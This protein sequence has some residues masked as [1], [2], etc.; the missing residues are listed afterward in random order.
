MMPSR[1]ALLALPAILCAWTPGVPLRWRNPPPLRAPSGDT[2]WAFDTVQ[3]ESVYKKVEPIR[4]GG[5]SDLILD[6]SDPTGSTFWS[7]SDRGPVVG[8]ASRGKVY[9][10]GNYHQKIY[11][12]RAE[13]D[14]L[15]VLEID[16]IRDAKGRLATGRSSPFHSTEETL[17]PLPFPDSAVA[18]PPGTVSLGM[19]SAGFDF[20][21]IASDGAGGFYLSDEMGP[22]IAHVPAPAARGTANWDGT[23]TIDTVWRP[24]RELPAALWRRDPNSGLEG[25]CR[26]PGGKVIGV[27]QSPLPN[28]VAK[29]RRSDMVDS[30]RVQRI[31]VRDAAGAVSE[32]VYLNDVKG[33]KRQISNIKVGACAALDENRILVLEHGKAKNRAYQIDLW[34]ADLSG[35]TDVHLASDP[36]SLGLLVSGRTLEE[37]GVDSSALVAAVTPVRKSLL[38]ADV[39]TYSA[40]PT[41]KPEGLAVVDD[42]TVALSSDN[43][44]GVQPLNDDGIP[45]ALNSDERRP[46][47]MYLRT[48]SLGLPNSGVLGR[49]PA[50]SRLSV[51]AAAGGWEIRASGATEVRVLDLSGKRLGS[52]PVVEGRAVLPDRESSSRVVVLDAGSAGRAILPMAR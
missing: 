31:V 2:L 34:I 35:A 6:A 18:P 51:S 32:H 16:S 26:T 14:S 20:E 28:A 42:S 52:L 19:D 11:R 41:T 30:S 37:V 43:D 49:R 15:R 29:K 27:M 22:W 40:W 48:K 25:L 46:V 39:Y 50:A 10:A 21:G 36:D 38:F 9:P 23:W 1:L 7:L 12:L 17:F 45:H 24:A 8:L 47:V 33:G 4:E 3:T 44:Y 5:F 13:G